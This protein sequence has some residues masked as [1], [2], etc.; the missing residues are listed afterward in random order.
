MKLK[1]KCSISRMCQCWSIC[2]GISTIC[3]SLRG[4]FSTLKT[5]CDVVGERR[6][7]P[8]SQPDVTSQIAICAAS[9]PANN[10]TLGCCLDLSP[11]SC[12]HSALMIVWTPSPC[13]HR[14][15]ELSPS[16]CDVILSGGSPLFWGDANTRMHNQEYRWSLG[17]EQNM[18]MMRRSTHTLQ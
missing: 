1:V 8:A 10:H 3:L 15:S 6:L 13:Y 2:D 9:V 18:R 7:I 16:C 17:C 4:V 5:C 11:R 12:S 14:A